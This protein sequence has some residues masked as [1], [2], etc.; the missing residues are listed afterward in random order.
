MSPSASHTQ[1]SLA[2]SCDRPLCLQADAMVAKVFPDEQYKRYMERVR[3]SDDHEYAGIDVAVDYVTREVSARGPFD[4][5]LGFSQGA[6]LV[7]MVVAQLVHTKQSALLPRCCIVMCGTQFG[8]AQ[9]QLGHLFAEK[10]RIP[11]LHVIGDEDPFRTTTE[12]LAEL[13]E[14]P[15]LITHA[16]GH[17]PMPP[18]RDAEPLAQT[19][20]SFML[21]HLDE[22]Q[23]HAPQ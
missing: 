3:V 8:W 1:S 21:M 9:R 6:N 5:M 7:T 18:G 20:L 23:P 22:A 4:C 19:L 17:R 15:V 10:L 2:Q 12:A 13:F 16:S 14:Q 11:S